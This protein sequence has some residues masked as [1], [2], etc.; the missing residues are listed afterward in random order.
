MTPQTLGKY[1]T[2]TRP[3]RIL[4]SIR[5]ILMTHSENSKRELE[6]AMRKNEKAMRNCENLLESVQ[7]C[8]ILI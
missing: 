8:I 7:Q 2:C 3:V 5:A 1:E 4:G 6:K